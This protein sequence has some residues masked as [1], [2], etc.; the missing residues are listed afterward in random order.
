MRRERAREHAAA[1]ESCA[2]Q[3]AAEEA[4]NARLFEFGAATATDHASPRVREALRAQ[5]RVPP[6]NVVP[7]ESRRRAIRPMWAL[8]AA[9]ALIGCFALAAWFWLQTGAV[10]NGIGGDLG[11]TLPPP[12]SPPAPTAEFAPPPATPAAPTLIASRPGRSRTR[13]AANSEKETVSEF[14]PLTLAA[15]ER[16]IEN[17]TLVRLAMSRERLIAMGLP[18]QIEGAQKTINAEVIMGDNGVAYAIRVVR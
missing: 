14:V 8:A 7:I 9:A 4:L 1:C 5:L 6:A 15:D 2:G 3:W 13:R 17:G 11:R 16:A 10:E 12:A 18:L